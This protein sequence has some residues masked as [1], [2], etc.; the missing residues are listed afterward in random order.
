MLRTPFFM[1]S[2]IDRR[3]SVGTILGRVLWLQ[4]CFGAAEQMAKQTVEV[5]Y[6]EGESVA[7]AFALAFC[8]CPV[9]I[10]NGQFELARERIA[11]LLRQTAE[12]SLAA[13]RQWGSYYQLLLSSHEDP[14][15]RRD[16][17]KRV[18]IEE[19]PPQLTELLATLHPDL[20][21]ETV[22][23]RGED[24]CAGWCAAELLR[25][26]ALRIAETDPRSAEVLLLR[27]MEMAKEDDT[28]AW[29]LRSSAALAE[30]WMRQGR[31]AEALDLL[32]ELPGR[33]KDQLVTPDIHRLRALLQS[34]RGA[35]TSGE[36]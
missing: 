21:T 30:L 6:R 2:Q 4:G 26:R 1:G 10:W 34:L 32:T 36:P 8:A 29:E 7:R 24:G 17:V 12:H 23:T 28:L 3:V 27:S 20:A 35:T 19:L 15:A 11:V 9:A 16:L 22:F 33:L 31:N 14:V 5:A 18:A 25:V 13:W